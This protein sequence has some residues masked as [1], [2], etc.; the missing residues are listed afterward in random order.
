MNDQVIIRTKKYLDDIKI[1]KMYGEAIDEV[2]ELKYLGSYISNNLM[3][4]FHLKERFRLTEAAVSSLIENAGFHNK[5][6]NMEVKVQM[7]KTYIRPVLLYGLE[8]MVLGEGQA[9]MVQ[10]KEENILKKCLGLST[11]LSSS[12]LMSCLK[13]DRISERLD[14][15]APSFFYRLLS[16][17]YTKQ[18]TI[19]L[20][21]N[22]S[23]LHSKSIVQLIIKKFG[24]KCIE[25][26]QNSCKTYKNLIDRNFKITNK[27]IRETSQLAPLLKNIQ[28]NMTEIINLM[29]AF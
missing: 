15:L 23:K 17:E 11:R 8:T 3:N 16:N 18:F 10:T 20:I 27:S 28:S 26:I 9:N 25:R 19:D 5:F 7:Y 4:K 2:S 13:L 14:A 29:R 24:T 21:N 22:N 1:L 6:L 12:E